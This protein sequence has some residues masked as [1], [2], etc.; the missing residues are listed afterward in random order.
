M[1]R[2][3]LPVDHTVPARGEL[4]EALR[5]MRAGARLTYDELTVRSG[6]PATT[7]KR[8]TSGR[9]VPTWETVTA[10]AEACDGDEDGLIGPLWR[11]ARIAERG[12]L[13]NLR[14]PGSPELINTPEGLSEALE[15]LY[16]RDGALS[17]RRLQARAGGAHLLPVSTAAR[18]VNRQALPASRQQCKAF[19][20]AC[21]IPAR[22]HRR[23]IQ[24]FDRITRPRR[25][26]TDAEA[27]MY[28]NLGALPSTR[29][30]APGYRHEDPARRR[31]RPFSRAVRDPWAGQEQKT[32]FELSAEGDLRVA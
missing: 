32:L 7:L 27:A 1:G 4:A 28:I 24:A 14:T 2:P 9:S 8:A 23:W 18:I 16:E 11:R 19:L 25:R 17:L 13:K 12:R 31:D 6:V 15:Y 20:T 22:Q 5:A 21:G 30:T 3:E 26:L 10:I 29:F